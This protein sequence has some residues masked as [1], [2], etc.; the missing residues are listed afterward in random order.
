MKTATATPHTLASSASAPRTGRSLL[1]PLLIATDASPESDAALRAAADIAARTRQNV[2]LFGVYQLLPTAPTELQVRVTPAE[3]AQGRAALGAQ[4]REQAA[5]LGFG[6]RWPVE[7]VSG[8]PAA[9]IANAARAMKASLI[10]MGIGKHRLV[11]R[12][13]G[14]ETALMAVRLGSGPV[15]AVAPDYTELPSRVVAAVDF[16]ASCGQALALGAELIRPGG[17]LVLAHVLSRGSD[18]ANWTA[19]DAAYRG[20][21]GRAM[22]RMVAEIGYADSVTI[23]RRVLS[24]NPAEAVLDVAREVKADLVVAG[25]HGHNFLTRLMLGS[26]STRLVRDARCSVLIAP[27]EDAPG[28]VEEMPEERG[29]FAFYEWA[30]RLE[31]FTRRNGGHRAMLEVIDPEIGAQVQERGA[32]FIGASYDPRDAHVH[33]MFANDADE[34]LTHSI[35]GVTGVQ[36]LRD[37]SGADLFLRVAH[38]RGQTLLTLER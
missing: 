17:T 36:M 29:R 14:E 1:G 35:G 7:I 33:L 26:V 15:L 19:T 27:R 22:D 20:T 5:R 8:D 34:H 6:R 21:V 10:V 16:S 12:L 31:E 23:E 25:T 2:K 28:F 9:M 13:L 38:G 30:E 4:V 24:G 37:R 18:A 3:E 11:D 32:R